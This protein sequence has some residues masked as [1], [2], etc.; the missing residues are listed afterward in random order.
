MRFRILEKK[1]LNLLIVVAALFLQ[2][3]KSIKT[4]STNIAYL[5]VNEVIKR[6]YA[7]GEGFAIKADLIIKYERGSDFVS[8]NGSLRMTKDS[9]IWVSISKLGFPVGKLMVTEDR[10]IFYEK[11]NKSFF[12]GDFA[13]INNW[14]GVEMDFQMFQNLFLGEALVD[15][16]KEKYEVSITE[17]NY[18]VVP[19]KK[20]PIFDALFWLDP[21]NF[22]ISKE[23]FTID[24]QNELQIQY[25]E[26]EIE[27]NFSLPK[28]F[29]VNANNKNKN[30]TIEVDIKN[31]ELIDNLRFPISIP[32]N[33]KQIKLQ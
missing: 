8:L 12:D 17:N 10:V 27:E 7:K 6:H 13:L 29:T 2:S 33:Y 16:R 28:G 18:F 1:F 20:N 23:Q 3:C 26:F 5:P 25:K 19:K 31:I 32:D 15:L 22:K 24:E 4:T 9:A 30:T 11:V 14:L 21:V